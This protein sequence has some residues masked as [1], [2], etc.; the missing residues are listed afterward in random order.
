MR[1]CHPGRIM[2]EVDGFELL[3]QLRRSDRGR[4]VPAVALT[5]FVRAEDR[6]RSLL[7]GFQGHVAKPVDPA[8]LL[9]AVSSLL[10]LAEQRSGAAGDPPRDPLDVHPD[11]YAGPENLRQT[12][13]SSGGSRAKSG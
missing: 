11:I 5:P 12:E 8:E 6:T 2:P 1:L 13:R 10:M 4:R 3:K 9:A 7:A